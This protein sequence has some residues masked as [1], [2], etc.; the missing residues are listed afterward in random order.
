MTPRKANMRRAD[1]LFQLIQLLRARRSLTAAQI[2]KELEV[3]ERTV[4]RDVQ[5][6]MASGVPIEGEAGVGYVLAQSFDLPP[7][8]F[9]KEEV[10]ALVVG[11]RMVEAWGDPDLARQARSVVSKAESVVTEALRQ[12]LQSVDVYVPSFH[13]CDELKANVEPVRRAL[14]S[15]RK[16]RFEY[17]NLDG[18]ESHRTVWPLALYFWGRTWT[19]VC[20]CELRDA[21]RHFR[22]DR[23]RNLRV[24]E[25]P[26]PD[27]KGRDLDAFI[28]HMQREHGSNAT[29]SKC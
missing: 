15:K 7:L 27:E 16:L 4:Y 19:A 8:M 14:A 28:A 3:S 24:L 2:A 10:E 26:V 29:D 9:T 11:A 5:D 17:T 6:L 22:P 18:I 25:D 1:R 13:V 20:W 23:M 21:F 12:R